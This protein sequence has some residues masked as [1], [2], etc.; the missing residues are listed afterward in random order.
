MVFGLFENS[1]INIIF[2]LKKKYIEDSNQNQDLRAEEQIRW[3]I[4]LTIRLLSINYPLK[5]RFFRILCTFHL[6]YVIDMSFHKMDIN[7]KISIF[8]VQKNLIFRESCLSNYLSFPR[9]FLV[10][11]SGKLKKKNDLEREIGK[12]NYDQLWR[13]R[14]RT[15]KLNC[16]YLVIFLWCQ[17]LNFR[18][19]ITR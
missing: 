6:I 18:W 7:Y 16:I 13:K 9:P 2:S 3:F 10:F 15:M 19:S 4:L 14:I 11:T 17:Y 5:E 1:N 12:L 8:F